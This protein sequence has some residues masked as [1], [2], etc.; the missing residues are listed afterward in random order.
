MNAKFEAK[1]ESAK[2][3][4]DEKKGTIAVVSMAT[5]VGLYAIIRSNAKTVNG[6]LEQNQLEAKFWEHIGATKEEIEEWLATKK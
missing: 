3:I 6:F 4:W 5:T 2:R 1:L